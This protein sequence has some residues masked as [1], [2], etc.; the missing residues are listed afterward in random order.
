MNSQMSHRVYTPL[1]T[2]RPLYEFAKEHLSPLHVTMDTLDSPEG[3]EFLVWW[4]G[5]RIHI[6]LNRNGY[7]AEIPVLAVA[8]D[9]S[10][11]L[12]TLHESSY[13]GR[14]FS[15]RKAQTWAGTPVLEYETQVLDDAL[16]LLQCLFDIIHEAETTGAGR[17]WNS[18]MS[19]RV[20]TPLLTLRPL[21]EFAKEHLS[22]P[23]VT[24]DT[25]SGLLDS[26]KGGELLVRWRGLRI[27]IRLDRTGYSAEIPVL[28]VAYDYSLNLKTLHEPSYG[29]RSF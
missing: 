26:P 21:Y 20:Y 29:W 7:S 2:L 23:H 28:A 8:Y 22:P 10:L 25:P 24:M 1:L 27:H 17:W 15:V 6:R 16:A 9:Y 3:G 11:N 18:Q 5:L 13:G 19:H 12:K 14:S 4:R